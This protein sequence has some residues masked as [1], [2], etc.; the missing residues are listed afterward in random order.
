[1]NSRRSFFGWIGAIATFGLAPKAKAI[2][3]PKSD[4]LPNFPD[5]ENVRRDDLRKLSE[6]LQKLSDQLAERDSLE[7]ARRICEDVDITSYRGWYFPIN[8]K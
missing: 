1:M 4:P 6:R 3:V 5:G 8:L 7:A 2:P